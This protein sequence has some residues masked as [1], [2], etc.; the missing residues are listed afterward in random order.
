M[1]DEYARVARVGYTEHSLSET[2]V[3][4]RVSFEPKPPRHLVLVLGDAVHNLRSSLDL[5][6]CDI[7][8]IRGKSTDGIKFPFAADEIKFEKIMKKGEIRRIGEDV[9][10]AIIAL[11][12]F[13]GGN[14]PLRLL[15]DLDIMDKH[16]LIIPMFL[17]GRY[18]LK[19]NLISIEGATYPMVEGME[20]CCA[21]KSVPKDLLLPNQVGIIQPVFRQEAGAGHEPVVGVL[22]NLAKMT[23]EIVESFAAQFG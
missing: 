19:T 9:K 4:Y 11:Q 13:K 1:I 7:A 15:H 20:V 10:Q 22:H 5:M 3:S 12:P 21:M 8:R 23:E 2:H 17:S 18:E 6:I 14:L 16:D